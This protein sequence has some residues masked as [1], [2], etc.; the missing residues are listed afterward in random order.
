MVS[1][2]IDE[3]HYSPPVIQQADDDPQDTMLFV[4]CSVNDSITDQLGEKIFVACHSVAALERY[5]CY[6]L[7]C[8]Q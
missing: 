1:E 7:A 8:V 4:G 5:R 2:Q 3:T 6:L